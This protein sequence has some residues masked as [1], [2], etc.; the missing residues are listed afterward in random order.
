[1]TT[2]RDNPLWQQ[3]WRDKNT[4]FHQTSVNPLLQEFWPSLD[5]PPASRVLVPLCGKSLDLLWL[6]EQGHDV[7]GI[8]LSPIAV[9]S[10]FREN[11]LQPTRRPAG[12]LTLW[13]QGRISLLCGDFFQLTAADFGPIDVVYDRA[14]LGALPED[15]RPAYVAH[16]RAILPVACRIFLLT[17]E[18][19]EIGEVEGQAFAV[20]DEITALYS[21]HFAID[22]AH[23]VSTFEPDPDGDGE[24][25]LRVEH[26]LYRLT[27]R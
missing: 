25:L 23:V 3:C 5:L 21:K 6:A 24:A 11:R 2:S 13:E 20:A 14:A 9:R 4:G 27:P 12:K 16:L 17:A 18:D 26:K 8:E 22:L 1:M 7:V 19:P 10:F 15:I